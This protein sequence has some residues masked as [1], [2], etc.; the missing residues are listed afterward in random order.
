MTRGPKHGPAERFLARIRTLEVQE[1][2]IAGEIE[3]TRIALGEAR[4][5]V[6]ELLAR[7]RLLRRE[8]SIIHRRRSALHD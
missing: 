1:S 7:E 6:K 4:R 3:G 2:L 5:K 8:A